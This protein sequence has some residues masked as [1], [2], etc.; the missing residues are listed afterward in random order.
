MQ[1]A[2]GSIPSLM[3]LHEAEES[4]EREPEEIDSAK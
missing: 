1:I 4:V 3:I 2:D